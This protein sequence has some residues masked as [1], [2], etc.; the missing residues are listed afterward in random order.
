MTGTR[1]RFRHYPYVACKKYKF[2][3]G[4]LV[5]ASTQLSLK[6]I[7]PGLNVACGLAAFLCSGRVV[8]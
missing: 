4:E 1:T 7:D 6:R 2:L 5:R 3:H 8:H